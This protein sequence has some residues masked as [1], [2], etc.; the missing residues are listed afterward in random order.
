MPTLPACIQEPQPELGTSLPPTDRTEKRVPSLNR[1]NSLPT[2][3][4]ATMPTGAHDLSGHVAVVTGANHGVG[5]ATATLLAKRGAAVLVAYYRTY[6][7][8]DPGTP[9]TYAHNRSQDAT[10]VVEQIRATGGQ[11]LSVEADLSDPNSPALLSICVSSSR[12]GSQHERTSRH[13]IP[14]FE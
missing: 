5:A 14:H 4:T 9:A 10:G 3:K 12:L 7:A 2:M 13:H 1:S 11:A 6:A 8:A